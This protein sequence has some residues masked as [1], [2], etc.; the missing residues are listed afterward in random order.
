MEA[1]GTTDSC[2]LMEFLGVGIDKRFSPPIQVSVVSALDW[3]KRDINNELEANQVQVS[4]LI[5]LTHLDSLTKERVETVK[6]DLNQLNPYAQI[7]AIHD[8]QYEDLFS[9]ETC[10]NSPQK[11]DHQKAHWSSC[12][13][14]LP[15]PI[16]SE[17][18]LSALQKVPESI[19]RIKGCTRLNDDERYSYFE[20]LPNQKI[21]IR[22]NRARPYTGPK[23]ITVGP[24]SNP[25]FLERLF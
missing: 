14:D 4:S 7:T 17:K 23:M 8:F 20:R 12:S 10:Q 11:I 25:D 13:V 6:K 5:L 19:I 2:S 18:L 16:S 22:S 21:S 24:G 9:L 15:D 3:Q 1:N